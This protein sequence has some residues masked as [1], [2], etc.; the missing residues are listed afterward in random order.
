MSKEYK[1]E[2]NIVY[3]FLNKEKIKTQVKLYQEKNRETILEY[4]KEYNINN[5]QFISNNQKK[6]REKNIEK[7]REKQNAK[8]TCI[9]GSTYIYS[10]KLRHFNTKKHFNFLVK[11]YENNPK[12]NK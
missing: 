4:K 7:I 2:Y 1:R 3:R 12:Y 6:Y 5:R 8:Q 10:N 9:C 11:K